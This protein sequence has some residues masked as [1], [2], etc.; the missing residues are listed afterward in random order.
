[1]LGFASGSSPCVCVCVYLSPGV[2]DAFVGVYTPPSLINSG[3]IGIRMHNGHLPSAQHVAP[4][5]RRVECIA[6][7][8]TFHLCV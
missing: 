6:A 2:G 7:L 1:M 5:R 8:F 4:T 3:K